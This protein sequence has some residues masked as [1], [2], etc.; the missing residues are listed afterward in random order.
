VKYHIWLG[1]FVVLL[2]IPVAGEPSEGGDI[3][4]SVVTSVGTGIP[5]VAVTVESADGGHAWNLVSGAEGVFHASALPAGAY[6]VKASLDGFEPAVETVTVTIGQASP[7][8]L[9]LGRLANS[10]EVNVV[11]TAPGTGLEYTALR[12]SGARDIG[13]ALDGVAGIWMQRRGA[14]ANDVIVRGQHGDNVAVLID[15]APLHGA[16]PNRMDPPTFHVDFAEVERVELGK[17]PF[18]VSYAGGLAG[19]INVV[20][21]P[22]E[23][24]FSGRVSM[25][26]GSFGYI[27][28]S[29]TVSGGGDRWALR[30]GYAYRQSGVYEDGDGI[31]FTAYTNYRPGTTDSDAFRIHTGWVQGAFE[32]VAG[33]TLRI[34]YTRQEADHVLYPALQMDA[35]YD[36]ADRLDLQYRIDDLPGPLEGLR[37]QAYGNR[38]Q[39]WMTDAERTSGVP[40][41]RG[42]SMGTDAFSSMAGGRVETRWAG[43]SFGLDVSRRRWDAT[44]E[45]AGMGYAPQASIPDVAVDA[46]G[47][48]AEFERPVTDWFRLRVGGRLDRS[49]SEA[50]PTKANTNLYYAFQNTRDTSGTDVAP[51]GFA[52][53]SWTV[54]KDVEVT[55]GVGHT[56]RFPDPQER[57]F[58]LRR[59]GSD[60]VGN[61]GLDPVRTTGLEGGARWRHDVWTAAATM[62]YQFLHDYITVYSQPR[63]NMVPGVMNPFARSYGNVDGRIWGAEADLSVALTSRWFASGDLAWVRGTKSL[64]GPLPLHSPYLSEIPPLTARGRIRYDAGWFFGQVEGVAA[65]A[66]DRVDTDVQEQPTAGYGVVNLSLGGEYRNFRAIFG[67]NNLLDRQYLDYFSYRRDPF[68]S[69]VKVPEPG[70][71]ITVNVQYMF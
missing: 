19:V 43:L 8:R 14:I 59:M 36:N 63:Q 47:A 53:A 5:G 6:R 67:V 25:A 21:A 17:G 54:G 68:A 45:M 70:R 7:V 61:P 50:D 38:V 32:P 4:G 26:G 71:G 52:Q 20:T 12:E 42:Y 13:E 39:H 64:D 40:A 58:A 1:L 62:Y 48:F 46:F 11:A 24:G 30:A 16:C 27:N 41:P 66:Q 10:E 2:M 9:S 31:P 3:H 22:P 15:G 44:T 49:H 33:Q 37:V 65:A 35:V 23:P 57:Y 29:A 51:S 34:D 28:P 56:V 18:D 60:W 69:G 55:T